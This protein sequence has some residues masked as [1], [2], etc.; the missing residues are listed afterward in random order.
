MITPPSRV[1]SRTSLTPKW[2]RRQVSREDT[3]R[4]RESL[5][6]LAA[7][8]EFLSRRGRSRS[9]PLLVFLNRDKRHRSDGNFRGQAESLAEGGSYLDTVPRD[10]GSDLPRVGERNRPIYLK[11]DWPPRECSA[12]DCGGTDLQIRG[13]TPRRRSSPK[14]YPLL[15]IPPSNNAR[16]EHLD[17]ED[18]LVFYCPRVRSAN[19]QAVLES[20]GVVKGS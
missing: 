17:T 8:T 7:G 16:S 9:R 1:D 12:G 2:G 20:P 19:S 10:G 5:S 15:P 11:R 3:L 6:V 18:E 13:P 14:P 4:L